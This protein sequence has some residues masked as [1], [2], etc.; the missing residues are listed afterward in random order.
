MQ[1]EPRPVV[2]AAELAPLVE[3]RKETERDAER[4]IMDHIA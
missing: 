2:K 3:E 4:P 1:L